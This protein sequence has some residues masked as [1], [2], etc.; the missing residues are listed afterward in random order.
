MAKFFGTIIIAVLIFCIQRTDTS[1]ICINDNP[2]LCELSEYSSLDITYATHNKKN[3][4]TFVEDTDPSGIT[5]YFYGCSDGHFDP[6]AHHI[7]STAKLTGS[8]IAHKDWWEFVRA[9]VLPFSVD[10][11]KWNFCWGIGKQ[12]WH[13]FWGGQRRKRHLPTNLQSWGKVRLG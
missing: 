5:F 2:C 8:V 9:T 3:N 6:A 7:N 13:T 12:Q 10:T 11:F 4:N 1:G